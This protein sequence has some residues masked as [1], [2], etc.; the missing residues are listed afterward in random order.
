MIELILSYI[1]ESFDFGYIISINLLVYFIIKGI[2]YF[3]KNNTDKFV[4]VVTTIIVTIILGIVYKVTTEISNEK[5][6]NS[7]I[8][9]P[10][11]WD[12]IIKPLCKLIKIDYKEK[13]EHKRFK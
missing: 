3:R 12:W 5:L 10:V 4:K 9:A 1:S 13:T 8:L 6:I 7:S 11:A 2:E